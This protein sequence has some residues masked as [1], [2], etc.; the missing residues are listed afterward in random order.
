MLPVIAY[1]LLQSIGL[2]ANASRVFARRC[3]VG[4]QADVAK[5]RS[6]LEQSPALCAALAPV[7]G[8]D[9]AAGIATL[10]HE[11]GRTVREV[12]LER[13]GLG[14]AELEALLDPAKLTEPGLRGASK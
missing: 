7:I 3:V 14:K 13:S 9:Q 2:L 6:N 1:N 10:A 8:Y 4:L 11:T 12:A 5:C